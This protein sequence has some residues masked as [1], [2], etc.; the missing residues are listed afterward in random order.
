MTT[1][2]EVID[3]L[4]AQWGILFPQVQLVGADREIRGGALER[5]RYDLVLHIQVGDVRH[6]LVCEVKSLGEPRYLVQ[7]IAALRTS[8]AGREGVSPVVIAPYFS[9]EGRTLCR[10][11]GINYVDLAGNML[12]RFDQVLIDKTSPYSPRRTEEGA[13][14]DI[15]APVSSRV[16]RVLLENPQ[17][18]WKFASLSQESGVSLR[19][20]YRVVSTLA[21]K[22]YVDKKRGAI[23]L[24]MPGQLLEL[25]AENYTVGLSVPTTLWREPFARSRP[26]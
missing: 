5:R 17:Q 18:T 24:L 6:E 15:F 9:D 22:G 8:T 12:L 7:A 20:A 4:L 16:L 2:T 26:E 23:S 3:Q 19:T 25:W 14:Y 10:E 21:E 11:A 1:K 13:A